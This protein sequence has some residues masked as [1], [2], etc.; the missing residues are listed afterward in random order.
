MLCKN[1]PNDWKF[2]PHITPQKSRG[3]FDSIMNANC[4][5]PGDTELPSSILTRQYN[6]QSLLSPAP[7]SNGINTIDPY[8]ILGQNKDKELIGKRLF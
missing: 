7:D 6:H 2:S 4:L 1:L 5:K 3:G 8:R